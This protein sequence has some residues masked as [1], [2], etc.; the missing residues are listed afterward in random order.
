MYRV[1]EGKGCGKVG[2]GESLLTK[3]QYRNDSNTK[4]N[5]GIGHNTY[6]QLRTSER[7]REREREREGERKGERERGRERERE[8]EGEGE[9]EREGERERERESTCT[10][11]LTN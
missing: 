1:V 4:P 5:A 10:Y 11:I 7:E 3:L 2:E 9:G 6:T 8:R